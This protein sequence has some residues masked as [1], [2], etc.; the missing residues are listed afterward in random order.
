MKA[1]TKKSGDYP[2]QSALQPNGCSS[3]ATSI[4]AHRCRL[5]LGN[6]SA[7]LGG[8][9]ILLIATGVDGTL[10]TKDIFIFGGLGLLASVLGYVAIEK[11][12]QDEINY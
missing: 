3:K 8:L 6:V 5:I 7:I 11:E 1:G 12:N 10:P 4:L 9:L 2:N